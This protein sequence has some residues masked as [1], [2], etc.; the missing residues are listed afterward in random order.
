MQSD[1]LDWSLKNYRMWNALEIHVVVLRMFCRSYLW[2]Q[3]DMFYII[4]LWD[5]GDMFYIIYLWDQGDM[6]YMIY[7]WDQGAEEVSMTQRQGWSQGFLKL[8]LIFCFIDKFLPVHINMWQ[9]KDAKLLA[10][11]EMPYMEQ[12]ERSQVQCAFHL[13]GNVPWKLFKLTYMK[14]LLH[15]L[16]VHNHCCKAYPLKLCLYAI[17]SVH[18]SHILLDVFRVLCRLMLLWSSFGCE[19]SIH[20]LTCMFHYHRVSIREEWA[21]GTSMWKIWRC[22]QLW[23]VSFWLILNS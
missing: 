2:D 8:P 4:Y 10:Q 13:L 1:D 3:G 11:K 6:F 19:L 14:H 12:E 22:K 15:S 20:V 9:I 7:L 23:L 18:M 17:L 21:A 16:L 5:W